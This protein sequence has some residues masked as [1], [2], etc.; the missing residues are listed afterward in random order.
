MWILSLIM[1]AF[2]RFIIFVPYSTCNL[3]PEVSK[4]WFLFAWVKFSSTW[5]FWFSG[6]CF[7][8]WASTHYVSCSIFVEFELVPSIN[9]GMTLLPLSTYFSIW[10][11]GRSL[12]FFSIFSRGLDNISSISLD[13]VYT[14]LVVLSLKI[15]FGLH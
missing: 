6:L 2:L 3:S 11:S 1:K 5:T 7:K 15:F 12:M 4:H 9:Y 13:L 14:S 10:N 8:I